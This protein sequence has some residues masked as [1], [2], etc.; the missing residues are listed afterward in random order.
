M[1]LKK[2]KMPKR[3][4]FYIPKIQRHVRQIPWNPD[5]PEPL[6]AG[7]AGVS[8]FPLTLKWLVSSRVGT[9]PEGIAQLAYATGIPADQLIIPGPDGHGGLAVHCYF[10]WRIADNRRQYLNLHVDP[11][12]FR[13]V[14]FTSGECPPCHKILMKNIRKLKRDEAKRAKELKR[15]KKASR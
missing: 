12:Y 9:T 7:Y 15:K 14:R 13:F 3:R 5:R 11:N 4:R 1:V 10:C 8:L 6:R 2:K